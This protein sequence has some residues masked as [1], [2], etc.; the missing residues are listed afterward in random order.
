MFLV[1]LCERLCFQRE[2]PGGVRCGALFCTGHGD[3]RE[4]FHSPA[5]GRRGERAG[6]RGEQGGVHQVS[7]QKWGQLG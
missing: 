6:H 3:P 1:S 5:E 7:K 4:G 2:Q